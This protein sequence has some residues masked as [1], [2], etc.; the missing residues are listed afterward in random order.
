LVAKYGV[1]RGG[2]ITNKPRG[3]HGCSLWKHVMMGWE[4]FA[5]HFGHDVGMG[6]R[7]LFWHDSWCSDRPF[8]ETFL[9][10]F[11]CSLNQDDFVAS[12][13]VSRSPGS[14]REWNLSFGRS[15]NDWELE[16]VMAFFSLIHSHTPRGEEAD[17][18]RW[19]LNGKGTFDSRSIYHALHAPEAVA[20]LWK[21]IW[22]V[23][24]PRRVAFF[25]CIVA[26]D[27]ILTYDN[28]RKKGFVLAGWCCMCKSDGECVDHVFIHC[29]AARLL[30]SLVFRSFGMV[31]VLPNRVS[32]LLFGWWNW[33]GKKSSGV[34]NL[35]PSCLMWTIWQ[36]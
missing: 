14:P 16:Q 35:I 20:F 7:V 30:W 10:L 23:K 4:V 21:I 1:V 32:D 22:G 11:G 9:V 27:R 17:K 18:L 33:F 34:W 6:D 12:V 2:W 5:S 31:W 3:T 24:S 28:L 19:R 36:E 25:M 8:K 26:W 29:G 15:F 13:L